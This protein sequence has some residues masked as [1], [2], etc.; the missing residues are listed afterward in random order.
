MRGRWGVRLGVNSS[1]FFAFHRL[2]LFVSWAVA[3]NVLLSSLGRLSSQRTMYTPVLW[4][5]LEAR[6][7]ASQQGAFLYK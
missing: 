4:L 5:A 3:F 2:E 6:D 7:G 1:E